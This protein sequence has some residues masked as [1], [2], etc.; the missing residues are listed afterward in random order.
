MKTLC[1]NVNGLGNPNKRRKDRK[2]V[3][4]LDPDIV[5]FLETK[6]GEV[7]WFLIRSLWNNWFMEWECMPSFVMCFSFFKES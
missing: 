5:P 4:R 7:D 3:R 6:L 2:V 1:W